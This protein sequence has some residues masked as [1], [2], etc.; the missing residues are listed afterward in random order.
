LFAVTLF[1]AVL[2]EKGTA[3]YGHLILLSSKTLLPS[4]RQPGAYFLTLFF[5]V[6]TDTYS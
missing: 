3:E 5:A 4:A 1:F 2:T 6:F